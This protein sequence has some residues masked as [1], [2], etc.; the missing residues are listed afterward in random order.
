MACFASEHI[1]VAVKVM[2]WLPYISQDTLFASAGDGF[3]AIPKEPSKFHISFRPLLCPAH[4]RCEG[5]AYLTRA[6]RNNNFSSSASHSTVWA[7]VC[8]P[9]TV[10]LKLAYYQFISRADEYEFRKKDIRVIQED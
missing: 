6:C 1:Y 7:N 3:T 5:S 10:V 8:S 2:T 9:C 4:D